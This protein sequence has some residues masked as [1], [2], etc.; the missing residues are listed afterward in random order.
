MSKDLIDEVLQYINSYENKVTIDNCEQAINAFCTNYQKWKGVVGY[1]YDGNVDGEKEYGKVLVIFSASLYE[2]S[3]LNEDVIKLLEDEIC[4]YE[5]KVKYSYNIK[6]AVYGNIGLCWHKLGKI[7]DDMAIEAYKKHILYQL[8]QSNNTSY[9][10]VTCYAFRGCSK[11]LFQSLINNTLN[12]SSPKTFNDPFDCPVIELLNNDDENSKLIREAYIRCIKVA[13]FV[14]NNKLPYSKDEIREPIYNDKKNK[15]DRAEFLNELMWSHYADYHK[16]ICI[17]YKFQN[18]MTVFMS[19]YKD[20]GY[21]AYFKDVEYISDLHKYSS[22]SSINMKDAFFAKAKSWKYENELRLL[23]CNPSNNDDYISLPMQDCI[24]A[25]YFGVKCSKKDRE[26][27]MNILQGRKCISSIK[28]FANGKI[29]T[30][31]NIENIAYYQMEI[32]R[33]KFGQIKA[34]KI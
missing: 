13:C 22:C 33:N 26:T 3:N 2:F 16:G 18:D 30:I 32:D 24:E 19:D 21:L 8:S 1:M 27:I 20:K 34:I 10:G 14:K 4:E 28:K 6:Y 17:K 5:I 11:F 25:I 15:R 12:L 29:E 31:T 9:G 23:Y 7:Y